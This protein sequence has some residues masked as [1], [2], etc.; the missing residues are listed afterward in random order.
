MLY[1]NKLVIK[2]WYQIFQNFNENIYNVACE[3]VE[4]EASSTY[5]INLT[6]LYF[7]QVYFPNSVFIFSHENAHVYVKPVNLYPLLCS[8]C[9]YFIVV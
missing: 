9:L 6:L 1:A 2:F 7:I 8:N 5:F 4:N 3:R